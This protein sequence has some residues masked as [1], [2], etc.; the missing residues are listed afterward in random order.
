MCARGDDKLREAADT[1]RQKTKS[2]EILAVRAD[3]SKK[4]DVE[5]VISKAKEHFGGVDIL[6][7]NA[8]GPK[9]SLFMDT[10]D[11]DWANAFEMTLMSVVRL[12]RYS[13]PLMKEKG[14][15]SIVNIVSTSVKQPLRNLVL[16]NSLRMGVVG[17]AK[18]LSFEFAKF[19][20]RVNN[21][22]PGYTQTPR[23]E[24]LVQNTSE[25]EKI[26]KEEAISRILSEVPMQRMAEPEEVASMVVYLSSN[27]AKYITGSTIFVDGGAIKATL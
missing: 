6:F 11:E 17:L 19:N 10:T 5:L 20:I 8:A 16:S 27:R 21:V 14:G 22:C 3:I 18:T 25:R 2:N 15:G 12:C 13:I 9:P 26:S 24:N 1:I 4:T 7:T 23:V